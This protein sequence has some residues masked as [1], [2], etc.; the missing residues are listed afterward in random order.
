M[1]HRQWI[2]LP[3]LLAGMG[4]AFAA[5][6][7]HALIGFVEVPSIFGQADPNGPPGQT[8]PDAPAEIPLHARPTIESPVIG[9]ITD[10]TSLTSVEFRYE[11]RAAAVYGVSNGWVLVQLNNRSDPAFGWMAAEHGGEFHALE[12]HIANGLSY[13]TEAWNRQLYDQPSGL[14]S[15]VPSGQSPDINVLKRR[16]TGT[17]AWLFVEV[18]EKG[19]CLNA[20]KPRVVAQ[21]WVKVHSPDERPNVW[22]FARGC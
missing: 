20:E 13:L 12:A 5:E 22:F 7:E 19:R 17:D 4:V 11:E 9:G 6:T 16:G 8:P 21:G 10:T 18:L 2:M 1:A 15:A 3:L 14:P